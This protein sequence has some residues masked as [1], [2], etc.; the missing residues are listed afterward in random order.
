MSHVC[1]SCNGMGKL[2]RLNP[3]ICRRC[4]GSGYDVN[5]TGITQT[6]TLCNGSGRTPMLQ[7][8]T[9]VSCNGNGSYKM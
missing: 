1:H 4:A 9:C 7:T 5:S 3:E 8:N 2:S 6:C